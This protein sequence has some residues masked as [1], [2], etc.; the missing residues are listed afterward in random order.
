MEPV[1]I[2]ISFYVEYVSSI[3]NDSLLSKAFGSNKVENQEGLIAIRTYYI[4]YNILQKVMK[5]NKILRNI[6]SEDIYSYIEKASPYEK[7]NIVNECK[8]KRD[9]SVRY[10]TAYAEWFLTG[11]K[12]GNV[13]PD[14]WYSAWYAYR[15]PGKPE[16]VHK[17]EIPTNF[18][19]PLKNYYDN[20]MP[21][22]LNEIERMDNQTLSWLVQYR[23]QVKEQR[24]KIKSIKEE[25][26]NILKSV[27]QPSSITYNK[28][29]GT[30]GEAVSA[31]NDNFVY[32]EEM[33]R[34]YSSERDE[35]I[36]I[37][38]YSEIIDSNQTVLDDME[39][40]RKKVIEIKLARKNKTNSD[41]ILKELIQDCESYI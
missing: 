10:T 33:E 20:P 7:M 19:V 26:D 38:S 35:E 1:V 41:S 9:N 2:K 31:M 11:C 14:D 34:L 40:L 3:N 12:K 29:S 5:E 15:L 39:L 28:F 37:K 32:I 18:F 27:F 36:L 30:L 16:I 21:C 6:T 8:L 24:I 4:D 22:V 13:N 25:L 17:V 23:E